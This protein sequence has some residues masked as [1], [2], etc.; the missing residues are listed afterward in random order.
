[1]ASPKPTSDGTNEYSAELTVPIQESV[2]YQKI[3]LGSQYYC[4]PVQR[5][6][7]ELERRDCV[8]SWMDGDEEWFLCRQPETLVSKPAGTSKPGAVQQAVA[9]GVW[10][11][12]V[13]TLVKVSSYIN[14]VQLEGETIRFVNER[15]PLVP[16][17]QVIFEW[18]DSEWHRSFMIMKRAPGHLM[19]D[20]WH[21]LT[22]QQR[23]D[24]ATEVAAHVKSLSL[25]T[26][27]TLSTVDGHG[28]QG[29]RLVGW[30]PLL[31]IINKPRWIPWFHPIFEQDSFLAHLRNESHMDPP[32]TDVDFVFYHPDLTSHNIFVRRPEDD[33]E[34]GQLTQ[35]IDWESAGYWPRFWVATCPNRFGPFTVLSCLG[36]EDGD[37]YTYLR[38]ALELEGFMP[39]SEWFTG[40]VIAQNKLRTERGGEKYKEWLAAL[41]KI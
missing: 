5:G 27:K 28:V 40:F 23:K 19:D 33:S 31:E 11:I 13:S 30:P 10:E 6:C 17:T 35:I 2:R 7:G 36:T 37:W 38:E 3:L 8:V 12:G 24:I 16:T 29:F 4:E 21:E 26:S 32:D 34:R 41:P 22:E 15:Q 39:Q 20:V 18:I 25:H 14:G 9:I 1:M